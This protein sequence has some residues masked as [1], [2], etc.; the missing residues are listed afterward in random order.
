M[1]KSVNTEGILFSF[2]TNSIELLPLYCNTNRWFSALLCCF[3]AKP[4]FY[5][6]F[7]LSF[8]VVLTVSLTIV[9]TQCN[10]IFIHFCQ[11]FIER[12]PITGGLELAMCCSLYYASIMLKGCT[13]TI[14]QIC[15]AIVLNLRVEQKTQE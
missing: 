14:V 3:T 4:A 7:V 2:F 6:F 10:N 12:F 11:C 15:S 5:L 9:P 13:A 8:A 1:V